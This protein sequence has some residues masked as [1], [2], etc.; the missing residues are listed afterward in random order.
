MTE[1]QESQSTP[2]IV[3]TVSSPVEAPVLEPTLPTPTSPNPKSES[4]PPTSPNQ[5]STGSHRSRKT[6]TPKKFVVVN[7]PS[8]SPEEMEE[9]EDS[10]EEDYDNVALQ[11]LLVLGVERKVKQKR[12][13]GDLVKRGKALPLALVIEVDE[14]EEKEL[15]SL[16]RKSSKKLG[17]PASMKDSSVSEMGVS[18]VEGEKPSAN[19]VED[20]GEQVVK[21]SVEKESVEK[22]SGKSTEKRKSARKL[23]KKKGNASEE[24]SSSKRAKVDDAQDAGKAKLKN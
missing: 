9:K 8:A 15:Y 18:N 4:Q 3:S 6:L 12:R 1:N 23:V 19:L 17:V 24:P 7:S 10:E 21:E 16:V 2:I 14:E 20:S 22:M 11:A 5:S 13:Q